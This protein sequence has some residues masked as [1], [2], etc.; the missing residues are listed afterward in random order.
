VNTRSGRATLI[1]AALGLAATSPLR[2][3]EPLTMRISLAVAMAPATL[4]ITTMTDPNTANRALQ[5]QVES[6]TYYRSSMMEVDG[7]KAASSRTVHY[8][9]VPGGTYEIRATLFGID[10]KM[11]AEAVRN[12]QIISE[13]TDRD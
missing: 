12:V 6:R 4:V 13:E 10:G 11:R 3:R 5:I 1:I 7:E 2:A 8:E 9:G